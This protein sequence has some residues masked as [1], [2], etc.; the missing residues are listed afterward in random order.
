MS[1]S[2][3]ACRSGCGAGRHLG[4]PASGWVRLEGQRIGHDDAVITGL[5]GLQ[6]NGVNAVGRHVEAE[7]AEVVVPG[8]NPQRIGRGRGQHVAV[9]IEQLQ[10]GAGEIS[11]LTVEYDIHLVSMR[12]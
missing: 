4:L 8:P 11:G 5:V 12:E 10:H 6:G 1:R 7:D 9:C 2:L 3:R